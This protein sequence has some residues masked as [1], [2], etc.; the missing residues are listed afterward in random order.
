MPR[1]LGY[2]P[3]LD[4]IRAVAILLVVGAHYSLLPP[5]AAIGVDLFFVLSGFLITTLLLEEVA[6]TGGISLRAFYERRAR[7]LFPALATMVA[8]YVLVA[9]A[10]GED[11]WPLAGIG[12]SYVANILD[13]TGVKTLISS[14]LAPLWSLAQEEQF[15]LLWPVVLLLIV[16]S[17][18]PLPWFVV[19]LGS[20]TL[21]RAVLSVAHAPSLWIYYGPDTNAV[22][23]LVGCLLAALGRQGVRGTE[24]EGKLAVAIL[25]PCVLVAWHVRFWDL[26]GW[27]VSELGMV[28]LVAVAVVPTAL[29]AAL[30]ARP[31]VWLGRR[32][33]SL[34]L[35]HMPAIWLTGLVALGH[36]GA[37]GAAVPLSLALAAASY[38]FVEQPFR[39]HRRAGEPTVGKT[40]VAAPLTGFQVEPSVVPVD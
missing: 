1:R 6:E 10:L 5:G 25:L 37:I 33:Y 18:R 9:T 24:R 4:G 22:G 15:Y 31:L 35:W 19:L 23:L 8:V 21:E 30:S 34:Y 28:L 29:A 20:F 11:R 17:R 26:V 27:P 14:P 7:R 16:R 36:W 39:R 40:S 12:V 13:A 38:R 3:A 2:V 32:S